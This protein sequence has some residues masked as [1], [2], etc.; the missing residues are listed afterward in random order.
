MDQ[1]SFSKLHVDA[2]FSFLRTPE[3][4]SVCVCTH[5][6]VVC[7]RVYVHAICVCVHVCLFVCSPL[8]PS[9]FPS[10]VQRATLTQPNRHSASPPLAVAWSWPTKLSQVRVLYSVNSS[11]RNTHGRKPGW[12]GGGVKKDKTLQ[13]VHSI[14]IQRIICTVPQALIRRQRWTLM[15]DLKQ[16]RKHTP[17]P[18]PHPCFIMWRLT[19]TVQ[20]VLTWRWRWRCPW[21]T[22]SGHDTPLWCCL[23]SEKHTHKNK[24]DVCLRN[25][26]SDAWSWTYF[27]PSAWT[28]L[29]VFTIIPF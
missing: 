6:H 22:W 7:I 21:R 2:F 16:T 17:S 8:P 1:F 23:G 24:I 12:G 25:W 18:P 28:H 9:P 14:V 27:S 5:V 19:C 10:N 13:T 15:K 3:R 11:S 26:K 4:E 29:N 20:P